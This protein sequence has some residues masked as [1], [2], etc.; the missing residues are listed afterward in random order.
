MLF[1]SA[2]LTMGLA[3]TLGAGTVSFTG[4]L[5]RDDGVALMG[6]SGSR[7]GFVP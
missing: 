2:L 5:V 6:F 7:R 4:S 3:A 1:N